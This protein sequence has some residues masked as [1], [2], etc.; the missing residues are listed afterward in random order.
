MATTAAAVPAPSTVTNAS[1]ARHRHEDE[2]KTIF[3]VT[4]D[5]LIEDFSCAFQ[6]RAIMHGRMY[7]T[8][9]A[10]YFYST[11]FT[12]TTKTLPF[13]DILSIQKR[14]TAMIFSNALEITMRDT[15]KHFFTSFMYRDDAYRVIMRA[16]R[17]WRKDHGEKDLDSQD[18]SSEELT[19]DEDPFIATAGD[20]T[21]L[22][23]SPAQDL[24]SGSPAT[25][26]LSVDSN[27][28]MG[29]RD[30]Y[31]SGDERESSHVRKDSKDKK[32]KE[33]KKLK[34]KNS[35][36][37]LRSISHKKSKSK[38]AADE[39]G[40]TDDDFITASDMLRKSK[41]ENRMVEADMKKLD[42]SW[43]ETL[44]GGKQRNTVSLP[45]KSGSTTPPMGR[46]SIVQTNPAN[47]LLD[48]ATDEGIATA[49]MNGNSSSP[50]MGTS[51]NNS[52]GG[53]SSGASNAGGAN[54]GANGT[55]GANG[56]PADNNDRP[57][58]Q[59]DCKHFHDEKPT[60]LLEA[61]FDVSVVEFY[62]IF[63]SDAEFFSYLG[64]M[65]EFTEMFVGNWQLT[66]EGC[67][68]SRKVGYRAPV[69]AP[70]GPKS[71]RVEQQQRAR[72]KTP[73]L[74][75]I[76][77]SSVSKDVPFG[78]SF[79]VEERW[80][81]TEGPNKKTKCAIDVYL[82]WKKN[83]WGFKSQIEKKTAE[84]TKMNADKFVELAKKR[85][86]EFKS[87]ALKSMKPQIEPQAANLS[88]VVQ[89]VANT[90]VEQAEI[91]EPSPS[92]HGRRKHR[93]PSPEASEEE[94]APA[95]LKDQV[96]GALTN[97]PF[98][99]TFFLL[100][101]TLL[102]TVPS[103]VS[104]NRQV[105]ALVAYTATLE[106]N[107]QKLDEFG[108]QLK[109]LEHYNVY[110]T[111]ILTNDSNIFKEQQKYWRANQ[112]LTKK[113]QLMKEE[114]DKMQ[115]ELITADIDGS[116]KKAAKTN[117]DKAY[118]DTLLAEQQVLVDS[119]KAKSASS[120]QPRPPTTESSSLLYYLYILFITLVIIGLS[121]A[122]IMF[123]KA[124]V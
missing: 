56:N 46:K 55:D 47:T 13:E 15:T 12:R 84:Y 53:S 108:L 109:F 29:D 19:D 33:E 4:D 113:L 16:W 121:T 79:L 104:L 92:T 58:T 94:A 72:F 3:E 116:S 122:W 96:L 63:W 77:T 67:C 21:P 110:L 28:G 36:K 57:P 9:K 64:R 66:E 69:K 73:T 102:F 75:L 17:H 42:D 112:D 91:P 70:I 117:D 90:A 6:G 100:A 107:N 35:R 101:I 5:S 80:T 41:D 30:A 65:Q 37:R 22:S 49:M 1:P 59:S 26:D 85:V 61:E 120:T 52:N 44:R 51:I 99:V 20:Q 27:S 76:E 98:M 60:K 54:G 25:N 23:E 38:D 10:I 106:S 39:L 8:Y 43:V 34:K 111:R 78:D 103:L 24:I 95:T 93:E 14:N 62:N 32:D 115:Q 40:D 105:G 124:K 68:I 82:R 89:T 50:N 88:A 114:I 7:I 118:I 97:I 18:L 81:L 2:F 31:S 45:L 71:T 123:G 87:G 86:D 74:L 11:I 83:A 119:L 48:N